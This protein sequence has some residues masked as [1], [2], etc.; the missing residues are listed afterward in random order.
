MSVESFRQLLFTLAGTF[1]FICTI[2]AICLPTVREV[3]SAAASFRFMALA[4]LIAIAVV[5]VLTLGWGAVPINWGDERPASTVSFGE[6]LLA[7]VVE[8][9]FVGI[10][11]GL[12]QTLRVLSNPQK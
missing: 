11:F 1:G 9:T 7:L 4:S 3:P 5:C 6:E 8:I 10:G 2:W 12:V